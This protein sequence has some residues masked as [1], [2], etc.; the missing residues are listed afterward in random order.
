MTSRPHDDFQN[1]L[2]SFNGTQRIK[3]MASLPCFRYL[4]AVLRDPTSVALAGS[5]RPFHPSKK[6]NIFVFYT[7]SQKNPCFPCFFRCLARQITPETHTKTVRKRFQKTLFLTLLLTLLPSTAAAA[8][9]T[10]TTAPVA[11]AAV[12]FAVCIAILA[13]WLGWKAALAGFLVL[14]LPMAEGLA[15]LFLK[16]PVYFFRM[17]LDG[18]TVDTVE[19][20]PLWHSKTISRVSGRDY[21]AMA[22]EAMSPLPKTWH[23][24]GLG[25]SVMYGVGLKRHQT[26][27]SLLPRYLKPG[28]GRPVTTINLAV[29]AYNAEQ[30]KALFLAKGEALRP[31]LVLVHLWEDDFKK[32]VLIG[33]EVFSA[34]LDVPPGHGLPLPRSLALWL[35]PRSRLAQ[36][37][38]LRSAG[39]GADPNCSARDLALNS[40]TAL[41]QS[42]ASFGGK[43]VFLLS[44]DLGRERPVQPQAYGVVKER[45]HAQSAEIIDLA[46]LLSDQPSAAIRADNCCHFNAK[47]H[48]LIAER[49]GPV[50][51]AVLD[52]MATP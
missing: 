46:A 8:P 38:S 40:L 49:L 42:A 24:A 20:V 47:G 19:Q 23:I 31:K 17:S 16:E 30:E 52:K 1:L 7:D 32:N 44:P 26:Y 4:S 2:E 11:L 12:L 39:N 6:T 13:W 34:S 25:D 51:T 3:V 22:M 41:H 15:R 5:P 28:D 9:V 48:Q 33:R 10:A 21:Q 37:I 35:A 43:A 50:L 29:P 14:S 45:L 27:M 18:W 36:A